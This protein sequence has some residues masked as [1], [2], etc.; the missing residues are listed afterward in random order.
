MHLAKSIAGVGC[1]SYNY[2]R[3]QENYEVPAGN[4]VVLRHRSVR[5][6]LTESAKA[7]RYG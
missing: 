6:L 5:G 7:A 4:G 3:Y 2:G 1:I